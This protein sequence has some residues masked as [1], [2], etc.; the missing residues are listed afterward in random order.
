MATRSVGIGNPMSK[1]PLVA[2][3][4]IRPLLDAR[5]P[6][7]IEPH[8]Y[9]SKEEGIA[10]APLAEIGWFDMVDPFAMRDII[11]HGTNLKWL[12]SIYAGVD[13]MP[14]EQLKAQGTVVTNGA[15]INAIAIAEYV[16]MAMLNIAKDYR[17]VFE[18]QQRRE[19]LFDSPGKI[20]LYESKVLLLGYGAISQHVEKRLIPFGADITKVRRTPAPDALTPHEWRGRLAEFDWVILAVPSTPDTKGMIG[21]EELAAMK[22]TASLINIARGD[23][24]DQGALITALETKEIAAAWLDVMIPEPL[25]P[26]HR[27]WTTPN[28]H[29]SSHLSG[30]AQTRM[31]ERS[32][33]RFFENLARYE[34]GQRL[35]PQ[36][37]LDMGY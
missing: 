13:M 17:R 29:I 23:V 22:P 1:T 6:E 15:G 8:W 27:L 7:W 19:W 3:A 9:M 24:I 31:F 26:E 35:E 21:A 36:V 25:P 37:D 18:A 20:E 5:L 4:L 10:L 11:T 28:A 2:S 30:R 32:A 14:L 34:T 12:N 16:I 33:N